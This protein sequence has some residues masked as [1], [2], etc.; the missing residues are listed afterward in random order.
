MIHK[1]K[2][3]IGCLALL[4]IGAAISFIIGVMGSS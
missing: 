3:G 4:F 2:I 1:H